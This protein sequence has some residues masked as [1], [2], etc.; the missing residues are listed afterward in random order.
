MWGGGGEGVLGA[1]SLPPP[2][3]KVTPSSYKYLSSPWCFVPWVREDAE[4]KVKVIDCNISQS[5]LQPQPWARRDLKNNSGGSLRTREC[6]EGAHQPAA[7]GLQ[8]PLWRVLISGSI[9]VAPLPGR[10]HQSHEGTCLRR[11]PGLVVIT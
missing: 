2:N 5:E 7:R 1:S 8:A 3:S 10:A 4:F 6:R 9:K 11:A